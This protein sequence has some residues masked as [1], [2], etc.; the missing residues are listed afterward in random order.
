MNHST[1]VIDYSYVHPDTGVIHSGRK[2][3]TSEDGVPI[4]EE[5][6]A[7]MSGEQWVSV[8][9]FTPLQILGLSRFE[10]AILQN[11][12]NLGPKM[13]ALRQWLEYIMQATAENSSLRTDWPVAPCTFSEAAAEA[14]ITLSGL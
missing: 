6:L 3:V 10:G 1:E 13:A 9:G 8:Q 7:P 14:R 4:Y 2:L 11:S 5:E 12:L